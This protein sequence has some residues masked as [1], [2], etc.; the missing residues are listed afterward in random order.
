[1]R[2]FT[3]T[4]YRTQLLFLLYLTIVSF[5]IY[6][7]I[8]NW[9]YD[10]PYI[11]YKY[12]ANISEGLG[13]VYNPGEKVLST[14]TPLLAILLSLFAKFGLDIPKAANLISA[15][16]LSTGAIFIW[17]LS[18][19][20]KTPY[21]GWVSLFL[22]PFF[23]LLLSTSG[24]ETSLYLLFCIGALAYYEKGNHSMTAIFAAFAT[25][26]RPDGII[27]PFVLLIDYFII[28][29]NNKIPLKAI[30]L[31]SIILFP[32]II[33]AF[34]Y[35]GSPIPTT[36]AT[37]QHQGLMEMSQKFFPGFLDLLKQY[38]S[39]WQYIYSSVLFLIGLIYTF[40]RSKRWW[41]F[42][43]W[44]FIYLISYTF[45]GVSR[46]FWYYAPL[47]PGFVVG[48]GL[49]IEAIFNN[50]IRFDREKINI[51]KKKILYIFVSIIFISPI[52]FYFINSS[53]S[54]QKNRDKRL[55]IYKTVGIWINQNTPTDSK[56]G[57]LEVGIIGFYA[58]RTM[59]D[60]AGLLYP[61]VTDFIRENI[62]YQDVG[63]WTLEQYNPDFIILQSGL[64]LKIENAFAS[65]NCDCIKIFPGEKYNYDFNLKIFSCTREN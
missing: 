36:L 59:I 56:I 23:P 2:T 15:L 48:I 42:F 64:F 22:Y 26:T 35:F 16:S 51:N 57:V 41:V 6:K 20:I 43:S 55:D 24:S 32:W 65:K 28:K 46:Y 18:N 61:N 58:K 13:F 39:Y 29:K 53:I 8:E 49:G 52:I 44:T 10:D 63:I 7:V 31:Y 37:K 34:A 5:A 14:T 21:V 11:T 50:N 19:S 27:I 1:M 25:L 9:G 17:S 60:F 40:F 33:F 30:G 3:L 45:L 47:V 54:L 62:D 4:K 12:A 38:S